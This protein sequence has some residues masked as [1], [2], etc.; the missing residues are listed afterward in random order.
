MELRLED[1][2]DRSCGV[3]RGQARGECGGARAR[4]SYSGGKNQ[5]N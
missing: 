5:S 2:L 1:R 3:L 4:E